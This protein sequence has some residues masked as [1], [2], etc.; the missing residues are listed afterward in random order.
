MRLINGRY[1]I[2]ALVLTIF[3]TTNIVSAE[4]I[5][6]KIQEEVTI[7]SD[8]ITLNDIA[9][10]EGIS[11]KNLR[12][13]KD[14][15]ISRALL[16]G[17]TK[18]I[19]REQIKL[20]IE[21]EG[22]NLSDFSLDIPASINVKT[23]SRWLSEEQL[24]D[25][26]KEYLINYLGYPLEK[27][28]IEQRFRPPKVALPDKEYQ[29]EF[30]IAPGANK[31][32]NVSIQAQIIVDE[33]VYKRLYLGFNVKVFHEVYIAK[34][35]ISVGEK[36]RQDD[37][38]LELRGLTG[39]RGDII[40]DFNNRI[41]LDGVVN[42]PINKDGVLTSYHLTIPDIIHPGDQVQAEIIVGNIQVTIMVKARRSG[43]KGDYITVENINNGHRFQAQVIN[44]HLLRL[45]Q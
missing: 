3:M 20:L 14:I 11:E 8:W 4:T 39:Y 43:K 24:I 15:K 22:F 10:F 31:T 7:S 29:I 17:Y 23:A 2:I 45:V 25:E 19:H 21:N 35:T 30:E 9:E 34:R 6:I 40:L 33:M 32:G 36:I 27:L 44:S 18:T 5:N 16:P 13:L 41:V 1:Y 38:Y 26:A 37:F 12:K 28:K 42:I